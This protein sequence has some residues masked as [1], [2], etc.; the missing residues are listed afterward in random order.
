MRDYIALLERDLVQYMMDKAKEKR[1]SSTLTRKEA[2]DQVRRSKVVRKKKARIRKAETDLQ[3][4]LDGVAYW[5]EKEG[6]GT[7]DA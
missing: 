2:W 5:K 6:D 4:Y 7:P 3:R 1:E